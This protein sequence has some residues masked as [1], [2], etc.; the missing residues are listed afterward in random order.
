[1]SQPSFDLRESARFQGTTTFADGARAPLRRDWSDAVVHFLFSPQGRV[2]RRMFRLSRT[3]FIA[4][5]FVLYLVGLRLSADSH[6]ATMHVPGAPGPLYL[7]AESLCILLAVGLTFWCGVVVTIKRWHDVD[8][9]GWWVLIGFVPV[10]GW[11]AQTV[12]CAWVSGTRGANT[13]G[14]PPPRK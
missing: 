12:M 13:Y 4:V 2:S 14:P 7:V 11:V 5:Y 8:R 9:S 6:A 3:M 1:M 10:V